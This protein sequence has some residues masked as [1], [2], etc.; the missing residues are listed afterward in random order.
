M[1]C[2]TAANKWVSG[3]VYLAL[4]LNPSLSLWTSDPCKSLAEIAGKINKGEYNERSE[5]LPQINFW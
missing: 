1:I 3:F 4:R 2:S 5:D